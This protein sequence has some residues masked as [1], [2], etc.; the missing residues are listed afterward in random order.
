MIVVFLPIT[1]ENKAEFKVLLSSTYKYKAISRNEPF[2]L[3]K[4]TLYLYM[5]NAYRALAA[6]NV[7]SSNAAAY[8]TV[9][10]LAT[11]ILPRG[12]P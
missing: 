1:V 12:E 7:T 4:I 3:A 6:P 11:Q 8:D 9:P 2:T 5:Y 10:Q